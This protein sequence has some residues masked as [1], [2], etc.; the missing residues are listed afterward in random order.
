MDF[1][2]EDWLVFRSGVLLVPLGRLNVLH[3]SD[4]RDTTARPL[5]SSTVVPSTWMEPGAGFYGTIYPDDHW[6][7]NYELYVMQGLTD[8]ISGSGLKAA[9]PS[10]STDFNHAKA[11]TARV[12]LSPFIGMD[13]G[14]GGYFTRY[15]KDSLKNL[16]LIVGD[17]NWTAGPFELVGEGGVAL[18]DPVPQKDASGKAL[19]DL[20]G[21]MWGYYVEAHYHL[22]PEF[23]KM[24]FLGEDF[25]HPVITLF[26]RLDQVDT[27]GSQLNANDRIQFSLGLNYRPIETTVFKL[28]YQWNLETAALMTGNSS[29]NKDNNQLLASVAMGY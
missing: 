22:F 15:D 21:P 28:E 3:D 4:Y 12:G 23:L 2:I 19:P 11:V 13:M 1:K 17:F 16:G 8:Q 25:E 20:N 5:F 6:E 27:S 29:F 7:V 18:F 10:L 24:S 14:I 26:A 9:R